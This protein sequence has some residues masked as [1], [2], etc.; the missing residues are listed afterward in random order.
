MALW[1]S[2]DLSDSL[3]PITAMELQLD[4]TVVLILAHLEM[5]QLDRI[6]PYYC[7]G[8]TESM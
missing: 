7:Q 5:V 3:I 2:D 4:K 1:I 6:I 8:S